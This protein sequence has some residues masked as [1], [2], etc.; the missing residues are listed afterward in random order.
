MSSSAAGQPVEQEAKLAKAI[1]WSIFELQASLVVACSSKIESDSLASCDDSEV[2]VSR[3][4]DEGRRWLTP[5]HYQDVVE[6]R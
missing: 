4:L 6:E 3:L 5:K 1:S 2:E